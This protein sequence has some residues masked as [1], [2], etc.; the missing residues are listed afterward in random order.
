MSGPGLG[1][2]SITGDKA[3]R[4]VQSKWRKAKVVSEERASLTLWTATLR[5]PPTQDVDQPCNHF[6]EQRKV[7]DVVHVQMHRLR[8]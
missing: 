4:T 2:G 1:P 6:A 7:T 5:Y 8:C 3:T